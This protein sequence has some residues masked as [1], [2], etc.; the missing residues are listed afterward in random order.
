MRA[1]V[2]NLVGSLLFFLSAPIY[3][4]PACNNE[5]KT[6]LQIIFGE[7]SQEDDN[8]CKDVEILSDSKISCVVPSSA[9][10]HRVTVEI[11]DDKIVWPSELTIYEGDTVFWELGCGCYVESKF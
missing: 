5:E 11:I 3:R 4:A 2:D 1:N 7:E 10:T 8:L 6:D 9:K